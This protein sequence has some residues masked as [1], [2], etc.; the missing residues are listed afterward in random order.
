MFELAKKY[1][2][3]IDMH[4]DQTKDYFARSLEYIA[5]KTIQENYVG[6]LTAAHCTSLSYQNEAHAIKV[7]E[8][9]F[10][11]CKG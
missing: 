10:K 3:D 7:I 4:V 9:T 1:N 2:L 5:Y 11:N 8:R 6:S